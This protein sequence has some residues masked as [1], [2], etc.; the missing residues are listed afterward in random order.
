MRTCGIFRT[1]KFACDGVFEF[2]E[3]NSVVTD[4]ES[5]NK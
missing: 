5:E 4:A 2:G 3:M 1:L